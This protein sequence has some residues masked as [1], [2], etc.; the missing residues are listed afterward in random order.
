MGQGHLTF[1]F[2]VGVMVLDCPSAVVTTIDTGCANY[3][4]EEGA[5]VMA[6][7][8]DGAARCFSM[9]FMRVTPLFAA[10]LRITIIV[11]AGGTTIVFGITF[12]VGCTP[13]SHPFH[14]CMTRGCAPNQRKAPQGHELRRSAAQHTGSRPSSDY[15]DPWA[16]LQSFRRT[17]HTGSN[18][19]FAR[20]R[21]G[22]SC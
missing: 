22:S 6:A 3:F 11:C 10:S 8:P 4:G 16:P 15:R 7:A 20:E 2:A 18:S 14:G 9:S 13:T 12:W 17:R 5:L 19:S 21:N 1:R